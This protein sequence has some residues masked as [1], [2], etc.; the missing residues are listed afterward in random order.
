MSAVP[1]YQ[2]NDTQALAQLIQPVSSL[3]LSPHNAL[4][5]YP[6]P[7]YASFPVGTAPPDLFLIIAPLPT[8]ASVYVSID[9]KYVNSDSHPSK[10]EGQFVVECLRTYMQQFAS[11]RGQC[12]STIM[13]EWHTQMQRAE[14]SL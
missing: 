5:S 12:Y 8:T 10:E 13:S 2:H 11:G 9:E 6:G 14:Q 7:A 3:S 4:L 1:L